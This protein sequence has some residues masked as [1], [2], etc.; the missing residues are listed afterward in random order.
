MVSIKY[1]NALTAT[2]MLKEGGLLNSGSSTKE[3]L[4]TNHITIE[5]VLHGIQEFYWPGRFQII[6]SEQIIS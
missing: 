1:Q 4:L 6:E 3:K 2:C 5:N